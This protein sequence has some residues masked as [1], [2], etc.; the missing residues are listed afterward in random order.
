MQLFEKIE[1]LCSNFL[2]GA[3]EGVGVF[4]YA[5]RVMHAVYF[6]GYTG[7]GVSGEGLV[8]RGVGW[9]SFTF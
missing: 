3:E 4:V 2:W 9:M 8:C 5:A 6:V 7:S 1:A